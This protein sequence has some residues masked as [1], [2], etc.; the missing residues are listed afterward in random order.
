[1]RMAID[2]AG[3]R[4]NLVFFDIKAQ[5]ATVAMKQMAV[6]KMLHVP[7]DKGDTFQLVEYTDNLLIGKVMLPKIPPNVFELEPIPRQLLSF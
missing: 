7:C 2:F 3:I 1:M 6:I 4:C 5:Q